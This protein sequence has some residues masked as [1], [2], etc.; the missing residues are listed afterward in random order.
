MP[1]T[2]LALTLGPILETLLAA[3]KTRELWAASY[4]LSYIMRETIRKLHKQTD[5]VEVLL[6]DGSKLDDVNLLGAGLY[7]DRI[8]VK[9]ITG[10]E[11]E[12]R[13]AVHIAFTG[14]I[15]DTAT[16]MH[17][18]LTRLHGSRIGKE[19]TYIN[20]FSLDDCKHSLAEYLKLYSAEVKL[21]ANDNIIEKLSSVC[22]TLDTQPRILHPEKVKTN[23]NEA[24]T[25]NT[26]PVDGDNRNPMQRLFYLANWSFLFEDGFG[27]EKT[28]VKANE[29]RNYTTNAK[30]E[31]EN[32][33][34]RWQKLVSEKPKRGFDSLVEIGSR[35]LSFFLPQG[36]YEKIIRKHITDAP[37]NDK[38]KKKQLAEDADEEA[39][40]KDFDQTFKPK[41]KDYHKYVAIV[42]ADGDN[43]GKIVKAVGK[44]T[45]QIKKFSKALVDYAAWATEEVVRYGGAPVYMGGDDMLFFAPVC[46]RNNAAR[47]RQN[48]FELIETLD[49]KFDT[50][51]QKEFRDEIDKYYSA[52]NI[53]QDQKKYPSLTFG[54]SITYYKYPLYE[55]K[56]LSFKNMEHVKHEVKDKNAVN[57]SLM[58]HSGQMVPFLIPKQKNKALW[59]A[60]LNLVKE[61]NSSESFLNSFTYKTESLKPLLTKVAGN[62]QRLQHLFKNSFNENYAGN[63]GFYTDLIAFIK[64]LHTHYGTLEAEQFK[65]LYGALRF[66]HFIHNKEAQPTLNPEPH[67]QMV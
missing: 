50:A 15:S 3:R 64:A 22:D 1:N 63:I 53:P 60:F 2:Y 38:R 67:E 16:K 48:I 65:L 47:S 11:T 40:I 56:D 54:I 8:Y 37:S 10:K 66:I 4:L 51:I 23:E 61:T 59:N 13:N 18:D 44:S 19:E 26:F 39:I 49:A 43:I 29:P 36:E 45:P 12:A 55:A 33:S 34:E 28:F 30:T 24:R 52:A 42:H 14:V 31:I 17:E 62:P 20:P 57:V 32:N 5:F 46:N 25:T 41:F 35:E 21:E 6:P 27:V 58:K 7:P 9:A